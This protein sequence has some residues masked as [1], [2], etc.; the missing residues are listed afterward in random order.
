MLI[1]HGTDDPL[2]PLAAA[3]E[4]HKLVPQSEMLIVQANHFMAFQHP[5]LFSLPGGAA[6]V[7]LRPM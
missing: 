5:E 1:I 2:V 6:V 3:L 4:H 7:I